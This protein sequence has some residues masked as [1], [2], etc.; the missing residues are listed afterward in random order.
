MM[1][2]EKSAGDLVNE[3]DLKDIAQYIVENTDAVTFD[4]SKFKRCLRLIDD[5]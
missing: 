5:V 4:D 3:T 1:E 2:A